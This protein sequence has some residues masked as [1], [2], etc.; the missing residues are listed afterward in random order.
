MKHRLHTLLASL[1]L[2]AILGL[3]AAAPLP[4]QSATDLADV[5]KSVGDAKLGQWASFDATGAGSGGGT[6]RLALVGTE[7]VGD[8]TLYW[9]EVSFAGKDPGRSGTVQILSSSLAS[10]SATPRALIVKYGQQPAMKVSG[11]MAGMMGEKGRENTQAFDFAARCNSARVIGWESVSVPAGTF[12]AL[13]MTTVDGGDVWASRD[14]PFGLVK[15]HAKQGDLALT[16]RGADAKSSIT[17]KP[18]DMSGMMTLP[19]R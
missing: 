11:E 14:V 4:A 9:F 19:K 10:R 6:L 13:H 8:S 3:P 15:T 5:C 17:E 12:R 2:A 7:R 1:G 18:V 16:G